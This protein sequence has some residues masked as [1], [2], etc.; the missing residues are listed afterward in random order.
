MV[1]KP[2]FSK[3]LID[4]TLEILA[5]YV[6]YTAKGYLVNQLQNTVL[7]SNR[8]CLRWLECFRC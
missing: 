1:I 2:I 7:I 3:I 6:I 5:Q 8:Y 4:S